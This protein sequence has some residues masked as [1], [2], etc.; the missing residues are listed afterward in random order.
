MTLKKNPTTITKKVLF[1]IKINFSPSFLKVKGLAFKR[2][3]ILP[4]LSGTGME[5]LV[6]SIY[7]KCLKD[8]DSGT[9]NCSC[10]P[11]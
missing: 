3:L 9:R 8:K 2:P 10:G 1:P 7:L 11:S 5:N 4:L 6:A